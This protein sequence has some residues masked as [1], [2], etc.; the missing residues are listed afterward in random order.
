MKLKKR[1]LSSPEQYACSIKDVR[2]IFGQENVYISFGFPGKNFS[3]DITDLQPPEINGTVILSASVNK[4]DGM[5]MDSTYH[6]SFYVIKD[7]TYNAEKRKLFTELYLPEVYRWYQD[8]MVRPSTALSG[9]ETILIEWHD[10]D[11]KVHRYRFH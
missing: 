8:M 2:N 1:N 3:F 7:P 4:R 10:G 9:I 11:F 6:I 5:D